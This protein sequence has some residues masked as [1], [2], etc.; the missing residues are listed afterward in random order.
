VA[1]HRAA[2]AAGLSLFRALYISWVHNPISTFA[3]CL[4]TQTYRLSSELILRIAGVDMTVSAL[5]QVDKLI[6]LL[7]SPIFIHLRLQLLEEPTAG[8]P[9][10]PLLKSLYGILMLLP[11][12]TAFTSLKTRLESVAPLVLLVKGLTKD[13]KDGAAAAASVAAKKEQQQ[14]HDTLPVAEM[15]AH[16]ESVQ[17]KHQQRRR[18]Q[19][20]SA[21]L[22]KPAATNSPA[23]AAP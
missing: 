18:R 16:F 12:S 6:Q 9:T 14:Q 11:Q 22:L 4:L 17:A 13:S 19:Q 2:S 21:S 23:A 1:A 10:L 7:E 20:K 15:L 8:G 5:M 3:L